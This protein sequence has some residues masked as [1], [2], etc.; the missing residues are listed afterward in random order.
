M[1]KLKRWIILFTVPHSNAVIFFRGNI[2]DSH[3]TA[4]VNIPKPDLFSWARQWPLLAG[5]QGR[6]CRAVD[7]PGP[8]PGQR[9]DPVKDGKPSC[10]CLKVASYV[11]GRSLLCK[12][13]FKI[14]FID[15]FL[16]VY[17]YFNKPNL[18]LFRYRRKQATI[19]NVRTET[20]FTVL[21][22]FTSWEDHAIKFNFN[23]TDFTPTLHKRIH[24]CRLQST[25]LTSAWK[26]QSEGS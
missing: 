8:R 20:F 13:F 22:V 1:V 21:F 4:T 17:F 23:L 18:W 24:D 14:F 26:V 25:I 7:R 16:Y 10:S 5:G 2:R 11:R 19:L 3:K 15:K 6:S 12:W 9:L